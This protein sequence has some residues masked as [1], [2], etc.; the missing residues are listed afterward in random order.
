L[1][2]LALVAGEYEH[3]GKIYSSILSEGFRSAEIY[4]NL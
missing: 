2:N 1:A 3:A 4:N